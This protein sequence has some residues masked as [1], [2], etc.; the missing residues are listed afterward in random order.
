MYKRREMLNSLWNCVVLVL[1]MS[2]PS[3]FSFKGGRRGTHFSVGDLKSMGYHFCDTLLDF[4]DPDQT[5][6][7]YFSSFFQSCENFCILPIRQ[8]KGIENLVYKC[9]WLFCSDWTLSK[10]TGGFAEAGDR[11]EAGQGCG[12]PGGSLWCRHWVQVKSFNYPNHLNWLS[13]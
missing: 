7:L 1:E 6:V 12:I 10:G 3:L 4:C 13:C 11:T 8:N 5:K 9:C 2:L